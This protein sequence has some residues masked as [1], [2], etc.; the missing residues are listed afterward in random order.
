MD[1]PT[2]HGENRSSKKARGQ[3][4]VSPMLR[5]IHRTVYPMRSNLKSF[6]LPKV[7]INSQNTLERRSIQPLVEIVKSGR[8][9]EAAGIELAYPQFS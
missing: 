5:V 8:G 1:A 2:V 6:S 9:P 7:E 3:N 4:T